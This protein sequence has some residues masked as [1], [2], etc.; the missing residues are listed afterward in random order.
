MAN[1][2]TSEQDSKRRIGSGSHT[3]T[4]GFAL[5]MI[6]RK[7]FSMYPEEKLGGLI[8][9]PSSQ[10]DNVDELFQGIRN[11]MSSGT[12]CVSGSFHLSWTKSCQRFWE[13]MLCFHCSISLTWCLVVLL[14]CLVLSSLVVVLSSLGLSSHIL[15]CHVLSWLVLSCHELTSPD[16]R[17]LTKSTV[18]TKRVSAALTSQI[19]YHDVHKTLLKYSTR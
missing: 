6:D 4:C 2:L 14:S 19:V 12:G 16:S 15:D 18:Q 7:K 9:F 11:V 1:E 13:V 3:A 17:R 8:N 10:W 5:A